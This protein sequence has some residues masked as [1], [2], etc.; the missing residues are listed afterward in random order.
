MSHRAGVGLRKLYER[1]REGGHGFFASNVTH[2]DVLVGLLR[3]SD[4]TDSDLVVQLGREEAA[5]FGDG[6]PTVGLRV[7]GD[8][9]DAFGARFDIETFCNVD[10]VHLP[11]DADFLEA[12]LDSGVP[13]SVMVDASAEPFERNVELTREAVEHAAGEVFVEAE[14]GRIAGVEGSTKTPDDEAFYTDADDAV[15]FVERTGCD[16]L[17]VSVGTQ[18]GVASGRDLDV[19]PDVA[20]DIGRALADAGSDAFLVVHGASG[21]A[22]EQLAALL[23]AG[24]VKFNKNTRYQYEYARTAADFYREHADAVRPPDGVAD[25]RAGFFAEA[26]WG[27]DKTYF[28]PHVVSN[29]ARDRIADV[30]AGLCE[31]TGSAGESRRADR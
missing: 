29:A 17:A 15:E 2:F 1:A 14:L 28:H 12:C 6:D 23:D 13:N 5:F 26:D 30:M 4:R 31:L 19:R 11:E 27:P 24:V 21:L 22:D 10:H 16:L 7:F 18:H 20:A 8:C 25:D 9:L 3:G